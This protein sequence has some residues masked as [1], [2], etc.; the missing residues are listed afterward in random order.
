MRSRNRKLATAGCLGVAALL[1]LSAGDSSAQK[2]KPSEDN[3][4]IRVNVEMVSLPVVVSTHDGR[5]ITDLKKEDFQV[6]EDGVQ[7]QIAGFAATDEP[8]SIVLALDTSGST[9]NDLA[10]IQNAAIDFVN[11]LHPDDRVAI[12]SFSDD[13]KLQRDFSSDRDV[14]AYGIKQTRPG[15][16]TVEYEAVWLALEEVLKPV[17]E[18]KALVLFTDGVDTCSHKASMNETLEL[19][20][21]TAA[22]IYVVYYNTEGDM[23]ARGVGPTVGGYPMPGGYPVPGGMPPMG[24]PYPPVYGPGSTH[25]EYMA[26]RNY[27]SKLAEYS[28]GLLFDGMQDLSVAFDQV[29]KELAS[30]YSIGYYSTNDKHDGK[31]R[32]IEVKVDKPGLAART[33]KGYYAKKDKGR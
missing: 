9:E 13:V 32:K 1:C 10:R 19:A 28:G 18:R 31:F 24:R 5:R 15:G 33:K 23:Y 8:L 25:G 27:L 29:A 14:N 22:T 17:T 30:Q 12:L 2:R 3:Q 7:Q 21:E 16:C 26:G 4:T 6:Y 11:A 20:K